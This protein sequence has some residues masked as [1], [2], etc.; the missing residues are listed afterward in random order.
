[1]SAFRARVHGGIIA[2]R[3]RA[4]DALTERLCPTAS[5]QDTDPVA[6]SVAKCAGASVTRRGF[7]CSEPQPKLGSCCQL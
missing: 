4:R 3:R 2:A 7:T 5:V 1:M 6:A